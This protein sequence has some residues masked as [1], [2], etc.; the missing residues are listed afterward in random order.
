[1]LYNR[2]NE[3]VALN[4]TP[5]PF[6]RGL[7]TAAIIGI[8]AAA[9][10]ATTGVAASIASNKVNSVNTSNT[11]ATNYAIAQD[12]NETNK[13]I[14]DANNALQ[15][16]LQNKMNEYN[17]IGAQ[18]QRGRE[19]GVNPNSIIGG[20]V[21]GNVQTTLPQMQSPVMEIFKNLP[22]LQENPMRDFT[23]SFSKI[24]QSLIGIKKT[25]AETNKI[26]AET[27]WQKVQ[28]EFQ[29]DTIALDMQL[30]QSEIENYVS[31]TKVN[32][33]NVVNL[34]ESVKQ[35]Q[36]MVTNL[37][38]QTYDLTMKNAFSK[39]FYE[40]SVRK[41]KADMEYSE[42]EA[43]YAIP[44]ILS[45]IGLNNANAYLAKYQGD[46]YKVEASLAPARLREI[47]AHIGLLQNQSA[48]AYERYQT[49]ITLRPFRAG[50]ANAEKVD[51][52]WHNQPV[53]RFIDSVGGITRMAGIMVGFGR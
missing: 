45:A 13:E 38:E 37:G 43:R 42:A 34:Q 20:S 48:E 51:K 31:Q 27:D 8:A 53:T 15:I 2:V 22:F 4:A 12:T 39:E 1:M 17:S 24:S 50:I 7:E 35:I 30:K 10:T 36:A 41:L 32:Y 33:Q 26:V 28:N 16:Q 49:E 29:R 19:A 5:L 21:S 9:A 52:N 18:I 3:V 11:N 46:Y 47:E 23:D 40:Y 14:A 25:Q 6:K 44:R